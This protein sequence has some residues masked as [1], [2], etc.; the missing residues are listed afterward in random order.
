MLL[1]QIASQIQISEWLWCLPWNHRTNLDKTHQDQSFMHPYWLSLGTS[2]L[3]SHHF[4]LDFMLIF[5]LASQ[6][7]ISSGYGTSHETKGLI[8]TKLT[9]ISLLCIHTDCLVPSQTHLRASFTSFT[10]FLPRF[11]ANFSPSQP[12]SNFE[13]LWRLPPN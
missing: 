8:L 12:N 5:H 3:H 9:R 4:C 1:F 7:Q 6:I 2:S 10:P 13:W 11:H